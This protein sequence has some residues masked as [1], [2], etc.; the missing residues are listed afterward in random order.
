M[1]LLNTP[2]RR[3][4]SSIVAILLLLSGLVLIGSASL[5]AAATLTP[6]P[7]C[8]SGWTCVAMPCPNAGACGQVEVGPTSNLGTDQWVFV[9]LYGFSNSDSV[10]TYYCQDTGNLNPS[11]NCAMN[12]SALLSYPFTVVKPFADG[13]SGFSFNVP[14]VDEASGTPLSG[15][16][17]PSPPTTETFYCTQTE[18]CAI[19]ISSR[20]LSANNSLTP[21]PR[22]AVRIPL[23]FA[24]PSNG[25]PSGRIIS[26]ESE[27]GIERLLPREASYLCSG[28]HPSL[29]LNTAINGREAVTA[30]AEGIVP[31]AFTDD[32]NA[33]SQQA[34]LKKGN[35]ILIPIALS[36]NV[37]AYRAQISDGFTVYPKGQLSVTANVAAGILSGAYQAPSTADLV[38]CNGPCSTPLRGPCFHPT[39]DCS[40]FSQVNNDAGF[41]TTKAYGAYPR[42]DTAGATSQTLSWICSLPPATAN[43]NGN[44]TERQSGAQVLMAGF[45]A[46]T[47]T[48]YSSCP[49]TDQF[50]PL[51]ISGDQFSEVNSPSQQVIKMSKFVLPFQISSG[52]STSLGIAPMNWAE[53][54]YYGMS[55]AG[56]QNA[57]G[58]LV[59]PSPE[60]INAGLN[61]GT[62]LPNGSLEPSY[63]NST[64]LAAYP[65]PS[66]IYAA[67]NQS[68][69]ISKADQ[70]GI[71]SMLG[72]LLDVTSGSRGALPEGFAPLTADM[73]TLARDELA[74]AIGNPRYQ[75][76]LP[77]KATTPSTTPI[78]PAPA[79]SF[80][81][82]LLLGSLTHKSG[83][84]SGAQKPRPVPSSSPLYK[85][86]LLSAVHGAGG[87]TS[88]LALGISALLLGSLF[89]A[90]RPLRSRLS[91][92]AARGTLGD[93]DHGDLD[94]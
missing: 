21:T 18:H 36:A 26:T 40:F 46:G 62:W 9:R 5:A 4:S 50:P 80:Q 68:T 48:H 53:A 37:L 59:T 71:R 92:I 27:F 11:P 20:S 52:D 19:E 3:A 15:G 93:L 47:G 79:P 83:L 16:I 84:G 65:M 66:V 78:T 14:L 64:D 63:T 51:Q 55:A 70:E 49:K 67:V 30:L 73:V 42:S 69:K 77:Q 10:G 87:V 44:A 1:S 91:A 34:Q 58:V 72:K 81:N 86:F 54:R 7:P 61:D 41:F 82:T 2:V 28:A 17:P 56:L 74:N 85:P 32:P 6:A 22:N 29:P 39:G 25:C 33:A 24:A 57:A 12:G 88:T 43:F 8:P 45:S 75:I 31:V 38:A 60:S 13:S 89:L 76:V 94:D 35:F 23:S 90:W